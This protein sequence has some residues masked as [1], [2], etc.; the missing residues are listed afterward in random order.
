MAKLK[1]VFAKENGSVT[2]GNASGLNDAAA[3]VARAVVV[4]EQAQVEPQARGQREVA[5]HHLVNGPAPALERHRLAAD[6]VAGAVDE[7]GSVRQA[8]HIVN[9]A[10]VVAGRSYGT[11]RTIV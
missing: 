11:L 5:Q 8:A 7:L 9:P 3:A 2:A 10:I 6:R 4:V 1:A